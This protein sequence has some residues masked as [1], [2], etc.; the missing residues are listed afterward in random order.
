M[1]SIVFLI[2]G[3]LVL[4]CRSRSDSNSNVMAELQHTMVG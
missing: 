2:A 1:R 3:A 4:G